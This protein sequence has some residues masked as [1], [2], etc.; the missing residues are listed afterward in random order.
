M[1]LS[2]KT[3]SAY[4]G[5]LYGAW[6]FDSW[7]SW[8]SVRRLVP[9]AAKPR[10]PGQLSA[11]TNGRGA[12]VDGGVLGRSAADGV[13]MEEH[14]TAPKGGAMVGH[15]S[16]RRARAGRCR[17]SSCASSSRT[18][19]LVYICRARRAAPPRCVPARGVRAH[20][21]RCSPIPRTIFRS[22]SSTGLTAP[23]SGRASRARS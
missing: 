15:S 21:A 3:G 20:C 16:R 5:L 14:W 1:S 17:S 12:W 11:A 19:G 22:A 13:E 23:T 7:P 2:Y 6:V 8:L 4:P 10:V 18:A 9:A